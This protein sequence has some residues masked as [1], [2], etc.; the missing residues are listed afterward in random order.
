MPRVGAKDERVVAP[1]ASGSA[2]SRHLQELP[3]SPLGAAHR[4]GSSGRLARRPPLPSPRRLSPPQACLAAP[5][6][7]VL[8]GRQ[9][10]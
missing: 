1:V 8:D 2:C 6:H 5:S 3:V 7:S 4:W 10:R 9:Y